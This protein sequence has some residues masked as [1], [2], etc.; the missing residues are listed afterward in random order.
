M[1]KW[2]LFKKKQPEKKTADKNVFE[3]SSKYEEIAIDTPEKNTPQE[4]KTE[5]TVKEEPKTTYDQTLYSQ[6]TEPKKKEN[7]QKTT[8]KQWKSQPPKN[9]TYIEENIDTLEK[10][11][12]TSSS[13]CNESYKGNDTVEDKV[14]SV[15]AKKLQKK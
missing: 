6:G 10:R 11:K 4:T 7:L 5:E 12:Q 1:G 14:D 3:Q 15:I 8:E 13:K 9:I 2:K